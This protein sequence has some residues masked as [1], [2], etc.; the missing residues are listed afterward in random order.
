MIIEFGF[1]FSS[2][3]V[4]FDGFKVPSQT[5]EGAMKGSCLSHVEVLVV[6]SAGPG[7]GFSFPALFTN[8]EELQVST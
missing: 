6:G 2:L 4:G 3:W 8:V 7:V 5:P 1:L